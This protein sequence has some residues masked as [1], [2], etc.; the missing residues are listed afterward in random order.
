MCFFTYLK[1]PNV[2]LIRVKTF[3]LVKQNG[4]KCEDKTLIYHSTKMVIDKLFIMGHVNV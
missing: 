3:N 1:L 2:N 4:S